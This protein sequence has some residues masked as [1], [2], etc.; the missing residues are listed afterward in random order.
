MLFGGIP[1][2]LR[3]AGQQGT[4]E[5][6]IKQKVLEKGELLYN[7]VK[8]LLQEELRD[9]ST[10][11][12]ILESM[13]RGA[14]KVTDIAHRSHI[15]AKDLP[16][17]IG[18]LQALGFVRK[19][20]PPTER[21]PTTKKTLYEIADPFFL[22]WFRFVWSHRSDLELGRTETTV[23]HILRDKETHLGTCFEAVCA[24]FL[25]GVDLPFTPETIGR[26]WGH[27]RQKGEDGFLRREEIEIDMVGTNEQEKT[28][29]F[30]ECKWQDNVDA[31]EVVRKLREKARGVAWH[32]TQ[33]TEH[34]IVIAK[35]FRNRRAVDDVMLFDLRDVE[36]RWR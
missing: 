7:E 12:T 8:I 24:E 5:E 4:L 15:E 36:S 23:A 25:Q 26:W 16:K 34:Y 21:K 31:G 30:C 32:T 10:Y 9:P 6:T 14:T 29:L 27:T 17:Y 11:F 19:L 3:V 1:A 28:I 33:R 13:A 18:V 20:H 2:Y 22:F 35:S